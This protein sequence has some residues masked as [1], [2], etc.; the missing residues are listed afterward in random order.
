MSIFPTIENDTTEEFEY[1]GTMLDFDF[2]ANEF[3]LEYGNPKLLN[4]EDALKK[5]IE[6]ALKTEKGRYTIY[7]SE[8]YGAQ[9]EDLVTGNT[10]SSG[11]IKSELQREITE[12]LYKNSYITNVDNFAFAQI[13][14]MLTVSFKVNYTL[15]VTIDV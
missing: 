12:A 2:D 14:G 5:W 7:D 3:N 10:Y 8:E 4:G 6:K 13:D 15:E 9:I 11:F 1:N